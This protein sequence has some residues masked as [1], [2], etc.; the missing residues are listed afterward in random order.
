M[1]TRF[2]IP[3]L[4]WR[5]GLDALLGLIPGLGDTVTFFVS[6]FILTSAARYG[7]PRITLARMGMNVVLDLVMGSI[8]LL[9]DVFDVAWK[10]NTRNVA[11]LRRV[12]EAAPE[13]ERRARRGDWLFVAGI[14]AGLFGILALCVLVAWLLATSAAAAIQSL[15]STS[16]DLR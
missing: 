4:R 2:E 8:P 14:L 9:G 3:G 1:D 16:A 12:V 11:L 6:C 15:L 13:S 10:S 7:V 5:F